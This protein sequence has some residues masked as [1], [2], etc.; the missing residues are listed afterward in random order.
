LSG[1]TNLVYLNLSYNRISDFSPIADLVPNLTDGYFND[2][3]SVDPPTGPVDTDGDG[4]PDNIDNAQFNPI[5][6][7][8][9]IKESNCGRVITQ[10]LNV[11]RPTSIW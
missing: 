1:L 10:P 6:T 7:I 4:V 5:P 3:Q 8:L 2:N 9:I 11:N